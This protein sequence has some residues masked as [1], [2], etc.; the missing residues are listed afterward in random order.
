MHRTAPRSTLCT[1]HAIS[2]PAIR[3]MMRVPWPG[4]RFDGARPAD[5]RHALAHAHQPQAAAALVLGRRVHVEPDAVVAIDQPDTPL[6]SWLSSR[7][8]GWRARA[9]RRWSA[10]PGRRGR[11]PSRVRAADAWAGGSA[12]RVTCSSGWRARV[13]ADVPAQ[14]RH[15]AQIVQLGG[16]QVGHD[17]AQ[18]GDRL[19]GQLA[20]VAHQGRCAGPARPPGWHPPPPAPSP[21]RSASGRS[22][23]AT[24]GRCVPLPLLR[25][26]QLPHQLLE[27]RLALL[28]HL[29]EP[30]ILDRGGD[31]SGEGGQQAQLRLAERLLFRTD[32]SARPP[33][34]CPLASSG[35]PNV[36]YVCPSAKASSSSTRTSPSRPAPVARPASPHPRPPR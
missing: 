3:S 23:R 13:L 12:F 1:L 36:R 16:A 20:Q 29:V 6:A 31:L 25:V 5:Q 11:A 19:I 4:C 9:G 22:R 17:V 27:L 26:D 33:K 28:H 8:P 32:D 18:L 15:Q 34:T 2:S 24:R 30:G 7:S 21:A 14:R 35:T 10:P